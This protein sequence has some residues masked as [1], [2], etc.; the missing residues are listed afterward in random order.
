[1]KERRNSPRA[2]LPQVVVKETNGDYLYHL[3]L[4]NLSEEG[5]FLHNKF[6]SSDQDAFSK[7]SFTLP[8][9]HT[10]HNAVARIIREEKT[11]TRL[12]SA[13]EFLKISELDRMELKKF[14]AQRHMHAVSQ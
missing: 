9:G 14:F 7:L 3:K 4:V 10:V 6:C 12:G 1:M 8:N 5:I 2:H 13:Y 11:G